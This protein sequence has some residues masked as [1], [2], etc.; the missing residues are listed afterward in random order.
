MTAPWR[1][2][3]DHE[4][5]A[6]IARHE[7]DDVA[8]LALK[9]PP[10]EN[11]PLILDQ[12]K[13]RQK[14]KNKIPSWLAR[15]NIILPAPDL[16]EQA[17]SSA[18]AFYKA[19]LVE[20]NSFADLTAGAGV[21]TAAF[22]LKFKTGICVEAD[23]IAAALLAHNLGILCPGI[24]VHNA[25][26]ED[27]VAD[28]EPVDLAFIDPQRRQSGKRGLFRFE[29]CSPD[30]L[31]LL[32]SL[33]TK[34]KMI[35]IKTSPVLDITEAI[36][37][38]QNVSGVHIVEWRGECREVLYLLNSAQT[39]DEPGVTAI[40]IDDEGNVLQSLSFTLTEEQNSQTP[41]APPQKFLY[42][43]GPAFLKSGGFNVIAEK[44]YLSKLHRDT[45]LYTSDKPCP[46]FPGRKFEILAVLP[47]DKKS[48]PLRQANLT[49]RNFPGSAE[50]L[51][52]KLELKDGGDNYLFACTL[53][54]DSKALIHTRKSA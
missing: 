10:A 37:Q 13:S 18:T 50:S 25:R 35:L 23:E 36:R 16:V 44:F 43:P 11:Y 38:L 1:H 53:A 20:G 28:M 34:A 39:V 4:I 15:D 30:I 45:H 22:A 33:K 17:S 51:R 49:L 46:E 12:I 29:D 6:F 26:A 48:L 41:I 24:A 27:Y 54:D 21:D 31:A 3:L 19:S 42:E 8:E 32:P 5:Q 7:N 9:K 47:V 40:T 52:K 14:A 2:L